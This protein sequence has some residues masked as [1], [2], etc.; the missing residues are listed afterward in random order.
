LIEGWLR[1][2]CKASIASHGVEDDHSIETLTEWP[3][4]RRNAAQRSA[5]WRLPFR[6][7]GPAGVTR[8]IFI[9]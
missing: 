4:L 5:V 2:A 6:V 7:P 1:R 9:R 8:A 3:A